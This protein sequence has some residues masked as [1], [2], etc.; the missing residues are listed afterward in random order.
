MS[1]KTKKIVLIGVFSAIAYIFS[2]IGS[3]IPKFQG[4]LTLDPKDAVIV[5]AGFAL[6]PLA[7]VAI[8]IIVPFIEM[9]TTSTT[10][11]I[12]FL[13]NVLSSLA[14]SLIPA[15]LYRK[16]KSFKSA[17]IGLLT[18]LFATTALMLLWNYVVTPF[19]MGIPREAIADML[20]PVFLPFNLIKYA[21]NTVLTVVLYKPTVKILRK[22]LMLAPSKKKEESNQKADTPPKK[23]ESQGED[24]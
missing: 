16:N 20:L 2:C 24:K 14:F 23:K 6:G 18:G 13:M 8:S 11:L 3:I 19:Y 21:I 4:F 15:L 12:G 10:E 5:I 9:I 7:S 17:I 1:L 22:T